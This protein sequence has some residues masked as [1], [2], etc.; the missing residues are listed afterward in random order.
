MGLLTL[1]AFTVA[2]AV[3]VI[4]PGPGVAAIVARA[5]GGG[6]G[7]AVPL[8]FGILIGDLI[9]LAFAA[10]GLAAIAT[11]FSAV[12]IVV[13]V[14]GALYLLYVA[15]LFWSA[16]PGTEQIGPRASETWGRTA[17]AGFT[18]TMGNPKAI[19]FYLALLPTLVPLDRMTLL[20]FTELAIIV[21]A[22][23]LLIGLA[24]AALAARARDLIRSPAALRRLNKATG[25][26]L[27]LA[28]GAVLVR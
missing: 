28:A 23:M 27:A 11:Y 2:Y 14:A 15:W 12:F 5:L 20:G 22:V 7:S 10:F 9:F 16:K 3:V 13:R 24:Y 25:A 26:I 19:V 8:V 17:L 1:T 4:V 18:L 21:S 6:F